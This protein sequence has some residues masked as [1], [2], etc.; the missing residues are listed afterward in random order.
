[1]IRTL[2]LLKFEICKQFMSYLTTKWFIVYLDVFKLTSK[3]HVTA[4]GPINYSL[5]HSKMN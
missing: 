1:M 3:I 5:K 4:I 2:L